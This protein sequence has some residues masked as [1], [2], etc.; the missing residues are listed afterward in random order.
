[1]RDGSHSHLRRIEHLQLDRV[2]LEDMPSKQRLYGLEEK[3]ADLAPVAVSFLT[4]NPGRQ[5]PGA[6]LTGSFHPVE[7][8][9]WEQRAQW[10]KVGLAFRGLDVGF[11]TGIVGLCSRSMGCSLEVVSAAGR[12][13]ACRHFRRTVLCRA[14]AL[15]G[16]PSATVMLRFSWQLFRCWCLQDQAV[17]TLQA[18]PLIAAVPGP[19]PEPTVTAADPAAVRCVVLGSAGVASVC[20]DAVI[21][22]AV[23]AKADHKHD[24]KAAAKSESESEPSQQPLLLLSFDAMRIVVS[25]LDADQIWRLNLRVRLPVRFASG[26]ALHRFSPV[27]STLV[28]CSSAER[29]PD[30]VHRPCVRVG[31]RRCCGA[32]AGAAGAAAAVRVDLRSTPVRPVRRTP[33]VVPLGAAAA[34]SA[35]AFAGRSA[36][37]RGS[38]AAGPELPPA[39]GV[40]AAGA[41]QP[42][43]AQGGRALCGLRPTRQVRRTAYSCSLF[44]AL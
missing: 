5:G 42:D 4:R 10:H 35:A 36:A 6:L 2:V 23:K 26:C 38:E 41:G 44:F 31:I 27:C 16:L 3:V 18:L 39:G 21:C 24:A 1:M 29:P 17:R 19:W 11:P 25:Y 43:S 34:R 33:A 15:P 7:D 28:W 37:R 13:S 9:Q 22:S 8:D 32:A 30:P 14:A 12:A 20:V 40:P